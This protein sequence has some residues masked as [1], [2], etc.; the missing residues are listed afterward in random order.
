MDLV[1]TEAVPTSE[2]ITNDGGVR[3]AEVWLG[4]D[5]VDRRRGVKAV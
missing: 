2:G 4:I 5:V 1:T 3:V